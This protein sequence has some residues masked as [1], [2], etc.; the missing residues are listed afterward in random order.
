V[1]PAISY[2]P[3]EVHRGPSTMLIWVDVKG[4]PKSNSGIALPIAEVNG[5]KSTFLWQ[6]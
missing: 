4:A 6:V 2:F 3:E 5:V 1:D